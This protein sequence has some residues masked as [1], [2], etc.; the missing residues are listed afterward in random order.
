VKAEVGNTQGIG[1]YRT[2]TGLLCILTGVLATG[3]GIFHFLLGQ[4]GRLL[5][6]MRFYWD[7]MGVLAFIFVSGFCMWWRMVRSTGKPFWP[8]GSRRYLF[9]FIAPLVA[10]SIVSYELASGYDEFELCALCWVMC[11]GAGLVSVR[12]I[13]PVSLPL[14]GGWKFLITGALVTFFWRRYG[15]AFAPQLGVGEPAAAAVIMILCFGLFHL[16]QGAMLLL[17]KGK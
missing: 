2:L 13:A 5:Q 3:M 9:A 14:P 12:Q 17:G 10:G 7:W 11:Y 1:H 4:E 15:A 16:V 8:E 6:G